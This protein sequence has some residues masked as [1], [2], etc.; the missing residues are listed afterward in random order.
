MMSVR[1][2]ER[3]VSEGIDGGGDVLICL[4]SAG[5]EVDMTQQAQVVL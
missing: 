2:L 5:I 3:R 4:R 1:A